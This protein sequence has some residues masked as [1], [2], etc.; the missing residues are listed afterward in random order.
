MT[1]LSIRR[2]IELAIGLICTCLPT[3]DRYFQS[4]KKPERD[5]QRPRPSMRF[6]AHRF[7]N[8]SR[9]QSQRLKTPETAPSAESRPA[10]DI[11]VERH[12]TIVK[13]YNPGIASRPLSYCLQPSTVASS[14]S[15]SASL[16]P[17]ALETNTPHQIDEEAPPIPE[18]SSAR[19]SVHRKSWGP[20]TTLV[21]Y[22]DS[23]M[24]APERVAVERCDT[25]PR[26]NF[27]VQEKERLPFFPPP[28]F[29]GTQVIPPIPEVITSSSSASS[30]QHSPRL[31]RWSPRW[32][33]WPRLPING[34]S[35]PI[36]PNKD[37]SQ[38]CQP[39]PMWQSRYSDDDYRHYSV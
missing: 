35:P 4:R 7:L 16:D 29:S 33:R 19:L 8:S 32:N 15:P 31:H 37:L 39:P 12:V 9:L 30:A 34:P 17:G 20:S 11:Q 23:A 36:S 26:S 13:A 18:K 28:L 22:V 27:M 3:M 21:G 1:N 14:L 2:Q 38:E 5:S 10:P 25:E 6:R 24:Q